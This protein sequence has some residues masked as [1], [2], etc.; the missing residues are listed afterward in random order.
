MDWIYPR[1]NLHEHAYRAA[2]QFEDNNNTCMLS[3]ICYLLH[4]QLSLAVQPLHAI[5]GHGDESHHMQSSVAQP[6][7]PSSPLA[8]LPTLPRHKLPPSVPQQRHPNGTA[9]VPSKARPDPPP[10]PKTAIPNVLQRPANHLD[11]PAKP[12]ST[13]LTHVAVNQ[14][15]KA[16]STHTAPSPR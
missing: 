2:L 16:T 5:D 11:Q 7:F 9:L 3:A 4:L 8:H 10:L 6:T 13:P 1:T 12:V 15:P 14:S